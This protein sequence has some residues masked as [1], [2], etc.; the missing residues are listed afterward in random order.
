MPYCNKALTNQLT[1]RL[2]PYLTLCE[3]VLLIRSR[4]YMEFPVILWYRKDSQEAGMPL[5]D[6]E[7]EDEPVHIEGV[8]RWFVANA[9]DEEGQVYRIAIALKE[10][11]ALARKKATGKV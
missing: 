2:K 3:K 4:Q 10:L 6:F 8:G 5:V 1:R 7:W 11:E 9:T